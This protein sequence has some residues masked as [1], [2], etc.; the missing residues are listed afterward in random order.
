M[1]EL[2]E[3]NERDDSTAPSSN[4]MDDWIVSATTWLRS[5]LPPS[6]PS[7]EASLGCDED[8]RRRSRSI[9]QTLLMELTDQMNQKM[10]SE[11]ER[12]KQEFIRQMRG[13]DYSWLV[14][15][16][17]PRPQ[18]VTEIQRLDLEVLF[19]RVPPDDYAQVIG[20]FRRILDVRD[21]PSKEFPDIMRAV[22][23]QV[24][25]RRSLEADITSGFAERMHKGVTGL[26]TFF[27]AALNLPRV[28]NNVSQTQNDQAITE[29]LV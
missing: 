29:Q 2:A 25:S 13:V 10:D 21:P 19:I 18:P 14:T 4:L 11:M 23:V 6:W 3:I 1:I 28:L 22:V 12:E 26:V 9:A 20:S 7:A 24:L 8:G 15:T 16:P 5:W 17:R 27:S